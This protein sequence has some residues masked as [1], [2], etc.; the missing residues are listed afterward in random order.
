MYGEAVA[1]TTVTFTCCFLCSMSLF[2]A[3][4]ERVTE[5]QQKWL[6][7]HCLRTVD[8][9]YP[10]LCPLPIVWSCISHR[11]RRAATRC[12]LHSFFGTL[13]GFGLGIFPFIGPSAS[14]FQGLTPE[15][16]GHLPIMYLSCML[17]FLFEMGCNESLPYL[18][19]RTC[20]GLL[21]VL[22]DLAIVR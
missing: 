10:G 18:H 6:G 22:E 15:S 8:L 11:R 12:V 20:E 2:F 21:G 7:L 4:A 13:K 9:P 1:T 5:N 17:V 19:S 14:I 16:R 3:P